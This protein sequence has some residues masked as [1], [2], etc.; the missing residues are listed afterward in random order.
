MLSVP[1]H[2]RAGLARDFFH[3]W[4]GAAHRWWVARFGLWTGG[5]EYGAPGLKVIIRN[6]QGLVGLQSTSNRASMRT[7]RPWK[8]IETELL[9]N[10]ISFPPNGPVGSLWFYPT[11][12]DASPSR[13]GEV[14]FEGRGG[15]LVSLQME[16]NM[17]NNKFETKIYTSNWTPK[18]PL[19]HD[20]E[21]WFVAQMLLWDCGKLLVKLQ[22]GAASK[23][24]ITLHF[25]QH[26]FTFRSCMWILAKKELGNSVLVYEEKEAEA[27]QSMVDA[28]RFWEI[29]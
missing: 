15:E 13:A 25:E 23:C 7:P 12:G 4:C 2:F 6:P 19:E 28:L 10:S 9:R 21:A 27:A 16:Q 11:P 22:E 20:H 18:Q 5:G 24:K 29:G 26:H 8:W 17:N 3:L 14:S 1:I